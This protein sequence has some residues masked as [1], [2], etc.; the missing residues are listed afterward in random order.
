MLLAYQRDRRIGARVDE[1]AGRERFYRDV[2]QFPDLAEVRRGEGEIVRVEM[3][4]QVTREQAEAALVGALRADETLL[5][6][7]RRGDAGD[8]RPARMETFGPGAVREELQAAGRRRQGD[9]LRHDE[10]RLAQAHQPPR[11]ERAREGADEAGRMEADLMECALGDGA[12][13][14]RNLD[15]QDVGGEHV[16]AARAPLSAHGERGRQQAAGRVDHPGGVR[17]VE[18]EPVNQDA[19]HQ[20]RVAQRQF[21]RH[22][23][24]RRVPGARETRDRGERPMREIEAGRGERNAHAVEDQMLRARHGRR[25]D[26]ARLEAADEAR[27]VLGNQRRALGRAR[28][29]RGL[30]QRSDVHRF[31]LNA[32]KLCCRADHL[33]TRRGMLR[34]PETCL[35]PAALTG[36]LVCDR[37][38]RVAI[39]AVQNTRRQGSERRCQAIESI[40][41]VAHS[42]AS[43]ALPPCFLFSRRPCPHSRKEPAAP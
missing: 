34:S 29:V 43:A 22:A 35:E 3:L 19:I 17:V 8:R 32:R 31:L 38:C 24:H 30:P 40:K 21:G 25:R 36:T 37:G 11:G 9:A 20:R 18:I 5:R 41:V 42:C 39:C 13:P 15:A 7:R 28:L 12:E 14:R 27:Q 10:L 16:A 2:P 23:D 6:Q 1:M 33:S 26:R 4:L